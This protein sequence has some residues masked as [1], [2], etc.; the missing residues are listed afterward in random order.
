MALGH[1]QTSD[2]ISEP[3]Q[4]RSWGAGKMHS[5]FILF[6]EGNV[7]LATKKVF[8]EFRVEDEE[9]GGVFGR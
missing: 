5:T 3:L 1:R 4:D 7:S 6:P 2:D 9:R 8:R